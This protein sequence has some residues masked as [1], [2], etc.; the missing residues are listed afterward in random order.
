MPCTTIA[1][2]SKLGLHNL[3]LK[4]ID[5]I[6]LLCI[7]IYIY[8]FCSTPTSRADGAPGPNQMNCQVVPSKHGLE[9]F[10]SFCLSSKTSL[11]RL[12]SPWPGNNLWRV[13]VILLVFPAGD[14]WATGCEASAMPRMS[15]FQS[16]I[17]E[18]LFWRFGASCLAQCSY[19]PSS[20]G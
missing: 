9:Y 5:L 15:R 10:W 6:W 12:A 17:A 7:Y 18:A 8:I 1:E 11:I 4:S 2:T 16:W 20:A 3:F 19:A 14:H 13:L